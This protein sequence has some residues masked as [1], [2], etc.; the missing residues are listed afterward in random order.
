MNRT[1]GP[2]ILVGLLLA[3]ILTILAWIILISWAAF[4]PQVL[5]LQTPNSFLYVTSNAPSPGSSIEWCARQ[6][7]PLQLS[8]GDVVLAYRCPRIGWLPFHAETAWPA[9]HREPPLP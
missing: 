5:F 9:Q 2:L 4:F 3:T 6:P 7:R 8:N 1:W